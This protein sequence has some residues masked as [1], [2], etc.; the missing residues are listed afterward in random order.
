MLAR[1][2]YLTEV[3]GPP[4][5]AL[6][7]HWIFE[8]IEAMAKRDPSQAAFVL[9]QQ[10]KVEEYRYPEVLQYASAVAG[11]LAASGIQCGDRIG[12]IMEN[13]PQWVFMLLGAMRIGA[14]TVP[15]ATTLPES[16]LQLIAEHAGCKVI[17]ADE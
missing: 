7:R 10:D 9:D 8:Q 13:T 12:V 6:S 2:A 5:D 4:V 15:L 16:S 11:D 17:F 1:M 14:V 3:S